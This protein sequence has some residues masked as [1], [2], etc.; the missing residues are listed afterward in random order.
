M[1]VK[2]VNKYL[3]RGDN[4]IWCGRPSPVG[5]P[6]PMANTSQEERDRVCDLYANWFKEQMETP[7]EAAYFVLDLIEQAEK[8]DITLGCVCKQSDKEVRCHCD[9][10]KRFIDRQLLMRKGNK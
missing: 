9:T 5:N 1:A 6:W 7:T 4:Y 2:I 10:I 3:V 8:G